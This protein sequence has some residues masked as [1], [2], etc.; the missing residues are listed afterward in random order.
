M[1]LRRNYDGLSV[2]NPCRMSGSNDCSTPLGAAESVAICMPWHITGSK[3]F[4][5]TTHRWG[6]RGDSR[7]GKAYRHVPSAHVR[8]DATWTA[9][10]MHNQDTSRIRDLPGTT[11]GY[12]STRVARHPTCVRM[13]VL[14]QGCTEA[15]PARGSV[16]TGGGNCREREG[17][18]EQQ[19]RIRQTGRD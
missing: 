9:F 2:A 8:T 11:A 3:Q 19:A 17:G 16:R 12:P 18:G 13:L 6:L 7:G 4:C 10:V 14:V 5:S 1:M 15:T